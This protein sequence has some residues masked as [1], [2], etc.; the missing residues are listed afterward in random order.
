M[1]KPRHPDI[2]VANSGVF[3]TLELVSD[4]LCMPACPHIESLSFLFVS[5]L[6]FFACSSFR[7]KFFHLYKE[8]M[9]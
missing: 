4:F 9:P 8:K 5:C 3:V 1:F 6:Y 7:R 2:S